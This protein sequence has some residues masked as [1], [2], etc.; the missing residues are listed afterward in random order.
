MHEAGVDVAQLKKS[1][2]FNTATATIT[3]SSEG[4]ISSRFP[5]LLG[6]NS[7]VVVLGANQELTADVARDHEADLA[8]AA[9][10]LEQAEIPQDGN[11]EAFVI[12]KR[13]GVRTFFNPAPGD[14]NL[15]KAIL[16]Y[17]DI[18]CT[19]ENEVCLDTL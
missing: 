5:D 9:L 12:A 11:L 8:S 7:I 17:T 10:V 2:K 6:E 4:R 15:N 13:H 3:V 16:E 19:N 18:I 1:E 14:P